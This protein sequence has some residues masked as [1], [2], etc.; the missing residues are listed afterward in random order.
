M[1]VQNLRECQIVSEFRVLLEKFPVLAVREHPDP[2]EM[3]RDSVALTKLVDEIADELIESVLVDIDV[4]YT[5]VAV[6][7]PLSPNRFLWQ[8]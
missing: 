5:V 6:Q 4:C 8:D 1:L 3:V 2:T 7:S